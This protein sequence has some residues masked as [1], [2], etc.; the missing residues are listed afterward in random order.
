[1]SEAKYTQFEQVLHYFRQMDLVFLDL[2]LDEHRTYQ[3]MHRKKFL[4]M[5]GTVFQIFKKKGNTQLLVYPGTCA[6]ETCSGCLPD[7]VGYCFVGEATPHYLAMIF[8]VKD[9]RVLDMFECT[10]MQHE[11]AVPGKQYRIRIDPMI[12]SQDESED[13]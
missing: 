11:H 5:L 6:N 9:G 12:F 10:D 8:E 3:S 1:M 4:S 7:M 13:V 2:I